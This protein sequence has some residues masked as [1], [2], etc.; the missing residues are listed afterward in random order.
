MFSPSRMSSR[1]VVV[2]PTEPD[3]EPGWD[4]VLKDLATEPDLVL[5]PARPAV[6]KSALATSARPPHRPGSAGCSTSC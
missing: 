3:L 5:V 2:D 1:I 4:S 6:L